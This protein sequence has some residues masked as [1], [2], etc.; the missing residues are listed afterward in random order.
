M[1]E[2]VSF[3]QGVVEQIADYVASHGFT[4]ELVEGEIA[5]AAN[6]FMDG[7]DYATIA[8]E[9]VTRRHPY[10]PADAESGA[11]PENVWCRRCN[12]TPREHAEKFGKLE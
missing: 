10:E 3:S 9:I 6:L 12:C 4:G 5:L 7:A 1:T 11:Y 8:H 2:Y